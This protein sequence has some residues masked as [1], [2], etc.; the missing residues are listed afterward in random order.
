MVDAT[1]IQGT[2]VS[3]TLP[4]RGQSLVFTGTQYVPSTP[5]IGDGYGNVSQPGTTLYGIQPGTPSNPTN[6]VTWRYQPSDLT[7]APFEAWMSHFTSNKIVDSIYEYGYNSSGSVNTEPQ[8]VFGIEQDWWQGAHMIEMYWQVNTAGGASGTRPLFTQIRRDNLLT[9]TVLSLGPISG[10]SFQLADNGN[11]KYLIST[12]L[13]SVYPKNNYTIYCSDTGATSRVAFV[14][15]GSNIMNF[16]D[17]AI[18]T[19]I[20]GSSIEATAAIQ[21]DNVSTPATPTG[22]P[23][24]FGS[25]GAAKVKGTSGTITTFGPAEIGAGVEYCQKCV[26]KGLPGDFATAWE[27]PVG[28]G[29]VDSAGVEVEVEKEFVIGSRIEKRAKGMRHDKDERGRTFTTVETEDVEVPIIERRIVKERRRGADKHQ[30]HIECAVCRAD[31]MQNVARV[32][33]KLS[34]EDAEALDVSGF[35][36][37]KDC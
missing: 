15:D 23:V 5:L 29:P 36:L 24:I 13:L 14:L 25:G 12:D 8:A 30:K 34:P 18:A 31:W 35:L 33:A 2:A 4:T 26:S 11:N 10:G 22:G 19:K 6:F 17:A 7:K 27:S 9:T 3:S 37:H 21:L 16:G 1:S 28:H 32:L 20:R